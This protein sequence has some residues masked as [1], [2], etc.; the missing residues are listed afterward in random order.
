MW[1]KH[2]SIHYFDGKWR[3]IRYINEKI[4]QQACCGIKLIQRR[5]IEDMVYGFE[6]RTKI[7]VGVRYIPF[8]NPRTSNS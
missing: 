5:Q 3:V 6:Y 7:S 1:I 2:P 4:L 8:L